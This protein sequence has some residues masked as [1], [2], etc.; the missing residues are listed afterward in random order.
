LPIALRAH[1]VASD[2]AQAGGSTAVRVDISQNGVIA[3]TTTMTV[4]G[5]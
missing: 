3:G 4:V 2:P 5:E 1:I